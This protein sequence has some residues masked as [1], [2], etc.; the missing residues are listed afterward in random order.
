[1]I[2]LIDLPMHEIRM[3]TQLP[4]QLLQLLSDRFRD[5]DGREVE[6]DTLLA[7]CVVFANIADTSDA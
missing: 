4:L 5:L 7:S 3:F 1:M 2:C 6:A